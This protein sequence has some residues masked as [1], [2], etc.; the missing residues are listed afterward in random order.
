[1]FDSKYI[2]NE[3]EK[4]NKNLSKQIRIYIFGGG[5]MSFFDLKTA[6]KDI[7]V[8]LTSEPEANELINS[9]YRTGYNKIETKDLVYLNMKTREIIE[10]KDGFIW[11]IFVGR[12]CGGLLFS[13]DMQK[14]AKPFKNLSNIKTYLASPEDIFIFKA[15][16]SRPRDREDMFSLFSHG[17]DAGIIRSEI[18]NQAQLDEDKAWLSYFF[19]GLD[20]LVNEYNIIFPDY[21]EFLKLAEEDMLEKLIFEL[22]RKKPRSINDL[23]SILKCEKEEIKPILKDLMSNRKIFLIKEKY[24]DNSY[25][26]NAK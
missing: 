26:T 2:E 9:L 7:D 20:E 22:I 25:K 4:I 23:I 13:K 18:L 17:L 24:R 19:V 3:L 10:N 11:D 1:M 15:V 8:I 5:A 16:T 12:V 6:T 21:D 14:R